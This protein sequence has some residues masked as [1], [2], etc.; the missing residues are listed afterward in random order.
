MAQSIPATLSMREWAEDDSEPGEYVDGRRTD[1]EVPTVLHESIVLWLGAFF[2]AWLKGEGWVL[3][4]ET[5]LAVSPT[6][7]RKPD[8]SVFLRGAALSRR[9]SLLEVPPFIAVEVLSPS[10]RDQLRDRVD[11]LFEY[12]AFGIRYYWLVDPDLRIVTVYELGSDG[13]YAVALAASTGEHTV[14]DGLILNLDALW[15]YVDSI[16]E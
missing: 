9:S 2:H 8:L 15:A 5:K 7:G 16:P 12:A 11:K 13:R 1:E 6:R 10:P 14:T 3:G 4:S